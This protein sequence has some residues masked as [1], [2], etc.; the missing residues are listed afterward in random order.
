MKNTL[1]FCLQLTLLFVVCTK[2]LAQYY[3][4]GF[5]KS[6]INLWLDASDTTTFTKVGGVISA[7]KDK[8]N[9]LSAAQATSSKQPALSVQDGKNIVEFNGAQGLDIATN[10]LLA[11]QNGYN[12]AQVIH[13][14]PDAP[15]TLTDFRYG[16]YSNSTNNTQGTPLIGLRYVTQISKYAV[17]AMRNNT[18]YYYTAYNDLRG[19]W[20]M[21]GN[22]LPSTGINTY[23][24]FNGGGTLNST[25]T[26][27]VTNTTLSTTIG[28]RTNN[29]SSV[30]WGVSETVLAGFDTKKSGRRI[31]ETYLAAKWGL[32]LIHI[33]EPTRPY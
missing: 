18:Y 7:W 23:Y 14:Y 29:Y 4:G 27:H 31:I 3:P 20:L 22:Y 25:D 10:A 1:R 12:V 8:A 21:A 24:Y 33:S 19:Q 13:V 6:K 30:H 32:S 28:N 15:S 17:T 9:N 11:P 5:S 16:T 2:S 26:P